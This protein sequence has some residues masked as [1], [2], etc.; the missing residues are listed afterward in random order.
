[1]AKDSKKYEKF[2]SVF[3]GGA[4]FT[5]IAF[6]VVVAVTKGWF[7]PKIYYTTV[8]ESGEGV[9]PGSVVRMVGIHIG[10]VVSME[11]DADNHIRTRLKLLRKFRDRIRE[12]SRIV[13][14]RPFLV[15]DKVLH[16]TPG[17]AQSKPLSEDAEIPS[18]ESPGVM[19]L[20]A[21]KQWG[22]YF[23]TLESAAKEMSKLV[24]LLMKEKGTEKLVSSLSGLPS[25]IKGLTVAAGEVST[26]S[27]QM[28]QG[29]RMTHLVGNLA[30]LSEEFKKVIPALATIAPE[31]PRSSQRM[32]QALDEAV[33]TM[34]AMQRSYFLRSQTREIR[35][36]EARQ[37]E[38]RRLPASE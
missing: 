38:D 19:D 11:L 23:H 37:K 16:I 2:S 7:E 9:R 20:L 30:E 34:K 28:S 1:M 17:G 32:V 26:V 18:Q 21:G 14:E 15:G 31:L 5:T 22:P 8:L 29:E 6:G 24:D 27:K 12:D 13:L 25:L 4:L 36:E 3:V 10:T 33:I 35:E